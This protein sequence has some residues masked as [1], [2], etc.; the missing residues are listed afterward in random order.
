MRANRRWL[1]AALLLG[2]A[3]IGAA[4]CLFVAGAAAGVGGLAYVEGKLVE[5]VKGTPQQIVDATQGAMEKLEIVFVTKEAD[6]LKGRVKG[7]T[8][9]NVAV[10]V[11]VDKIGEGIC[12][13]SIR[14]GTFGDEARSRALMDEIKKRL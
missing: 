14:F 4:G 7:R 3:T 11:D 2:A 9:D 12:K 5:N 1:M 8:S 6:G 10:N 13:I